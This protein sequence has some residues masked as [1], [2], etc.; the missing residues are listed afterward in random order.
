MKTLNEEKLKDIDGGSFTVWGA[1]A[2][3]T[4]VIFIAGVLDG[5]TRPLTCNG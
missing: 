3:V 4:G 1:I 5:F 2:M